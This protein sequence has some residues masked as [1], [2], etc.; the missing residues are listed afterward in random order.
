LDAFTAGLEGELGTAAP[1]WVREQI[2]LEFATQRVADFISQYQLFVSQGAQY[3]QK[4]DNIVSTYENEDACKQSLPRQFEE[5]R[6]DI[7][8]TIDKFSRTYNLPEIQGSRL[9]DLLFGS[10]E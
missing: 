8:Q 9:K 3:Y 5:L 7:R 2:N 6:G 10:V 1:R 4:F